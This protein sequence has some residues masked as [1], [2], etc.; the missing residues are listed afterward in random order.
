MATSRLN[1]LLSQARDCEAAVD[2][3]CCKRDANID[4]EFRQR[5]LHS[6]MVLELSDVEFDELYIPPSK[7]DCQL[8]DEEYEK[9][10]RS[11]VTEFNANKKTKVT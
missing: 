11:A 5:A 3:F 10:I 9:E 8:I 7:A 1:D 4:A 6:Q 2:D